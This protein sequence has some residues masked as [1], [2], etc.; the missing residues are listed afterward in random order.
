VQVEDSPFDKLL[1][2]VKDKPR[3]PYGFGNAL[4]IKICGGAHPKIKNFQD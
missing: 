2:Q 4:L 1:Q 3:L